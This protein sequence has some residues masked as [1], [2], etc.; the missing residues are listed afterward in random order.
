M[1][2]SVTP[3]HLAGQHKLPVPINVIVRQNNG[4]PTNSYRIISFHSSQHFGSQS[5]EQD[6]LATISRDSKFDRLCSIT[7]S[8]SLVYGTSKL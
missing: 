2:L 6:I 8:K 3:S 5:A 1:S 4:M 7:G